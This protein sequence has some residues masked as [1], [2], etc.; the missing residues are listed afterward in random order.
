MRSLFCYLA[1][2]I[3]ISSCHSK[4]KADLILYNGLVY[5]V[6]PSFAVTEAVAVRGGII[7]A[8]GS[9][10]DILDEYDGVNKIDLNGKPVYPG[11]IDA[12]C[13]FYG[14]GIDM[15]K[16]NLYGTT[17]FEDV[18][19]RLSA[20]AETNKS[21]WLL[22]RGWD[23]ND[24][25]V[26][27]F[28]TK[29]KLDSLF[30]DTP[31]YLMRIDGHAVLCNSTALNLA[32]ITPSTKISGGEIILKDGQLTG[33]LI[34]NAVDL[35]KNIIPEFTEEQRTQALINAQ[36][37]CF[38]VGLTTVDDAG[39]GE[40]T[41]QLIDRLQKKGT[42]KM[43]IYAMI[44][45]NE[46]TL[47]YFFSH[48]PYKS[49]RLNVRSVKMYADGALGSR[50]AC[51]LQPYSDEPGHYG[52]LLHDLNFYEKICEKAHDEGF[53]VCTHAIGDSAVHT[54][55]KI[56]AEHLGTEND[57]RWRIEH[58]QIVQAKDLN[59]F[60]K[61]SI[62]PSV[63]PTHATSDMYWAA[64][65]LGPQRI[66]TAYAYRDLMTNANNMIAFGTDFPVEN[67]NPLYTFYAATERQD[68]KNFPKN[69]FQPE[70]AIKKKDALRAMTIWAAYSNFED[71]EK[72]S[73]EE[74]K[75]ADL[76]VLDQDIMKI[77]GKNVPYVKVVYTFL[78]GEK[79]YGE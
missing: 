46:R 12:H 33:I 35:A 74:G 40:D 4:R 11:F 20:F 24:W 9:T 55:L 39:L 57:R 16:C 54:I 36:K 22:G 52:F 56:Y 66:K 19:S 26:K 17:S 23:Q 64:Q 6:D 41:I 8:V 61:Y 48:G 50:G 21:E 47:K 10:S 72:G 59:E 14:Y 49:D 62:I 44:S 7:K 78:N 30:P 13:H 37:N 70:N 79:V 69:G 3:F 34:D 73:I 71:E 76:V 25:E 43:R 31:V 28:P 67:I 53:Q 32:K 1:L 77:D 68:L 5:T 65:R 38:A 63:Q 60:E 42:L 27:E 58:C 18:L 45:D 51:L 15:L 29:E 2:L 75:F